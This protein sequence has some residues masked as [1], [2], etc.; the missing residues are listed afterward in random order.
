MAMTSQNKNLDT[1]KARIS[2]GNTNEVQEEHKTARGAVQAAFEQIRYM[3]EIFEVRGGSESILF[4]IFA[5]NEEDAKNQA[6]S[7]MARLKRRYK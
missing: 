5:K 1:Y 6:Y 7:M 3:V 4:S 2:L